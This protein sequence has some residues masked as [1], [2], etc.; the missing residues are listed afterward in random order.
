MSWQ[1]AVNGSFEFLGALAIAR[2]C[3]VLYQ[4]KLV[5]GVSWA[6]TLFFFTWGVW[7]VYYYPHLGQWWS[8]AGGLAICAMNF[9]WV[10][11]M[12]YYILRERHACESV[13][14]AAE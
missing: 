5:R 11:L 3:Y 7:N 1:D 2:H 12:A 4:H 10:S 13:R 14:E 6:S 8:F 9:L